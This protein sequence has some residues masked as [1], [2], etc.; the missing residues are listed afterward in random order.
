MGFDDLARH[1][2][3]RDGR[4]KSQVPSTNGDE[5]VA[6]AIKADRRM[7]RTR[8]LILG[9]ILLVGGLGLGLVIYSALRAAYTTEDPRNAG[10]E[11]D[12]GVLYMGAGFALVGI[13]AGLLKT[14]RGLTNRSLIGDA[15][16]RVLKN[17][18]P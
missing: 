2:A 15:P 16:E 12:L 14:I 9:P 1:M 4:K 18:E 6:A 11:Q 17:L 8:D 7:N 10:V 3:S 13:V 5:I